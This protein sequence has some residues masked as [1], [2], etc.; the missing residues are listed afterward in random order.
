MQSTDALLASIYPDATIRTDQVVLT[1]SQRKQA[2]ERADTDIP[3]ALITRAIVSRGATTI[4]RAYIDTHSIRSQAATLLIALDA[5]GGVRRVEVT[6]FIETDE[7]RPPAAWL[8]QFQGMTLT[9]DLSVN[10]AVRPLPTAPS[11]TRAVTSAVRRVLAIDSVLEG[12]A[13]R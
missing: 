6:A 2:L 13:A 3:T 7:P 9:D 1:P 8:Q 11:T 4:G 5:S 10:R 12:G